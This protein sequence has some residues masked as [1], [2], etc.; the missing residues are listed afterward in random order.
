MT[1]GGLGTRSKIDVLQSGIQIALDCGVRKKI[2]E[3]YEVTEEWRI[4]CEEVFTKENTRDQLVMMNSTQ[5][6]LASVYAWRWCE[7]LDS[8]A[9]SESKSGLLHEMGEMMDLFGP[10]HVATQRINDETSG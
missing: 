9:P 6:T 10:L 1:Q 8:N 7:R 4:A 2:Y 5:W 3:V